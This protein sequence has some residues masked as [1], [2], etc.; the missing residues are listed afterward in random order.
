MSAVFGRG[1][2][3]HSGVG[4]I[5]RARSLPVSPMAD[6]PGTSEGAHDKVAGSVGLRTIGAAAV[7]RKTALG[8]GERLAG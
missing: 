5:L 8:A 4:L 3:A 1:G 2:C 6:E 7:R